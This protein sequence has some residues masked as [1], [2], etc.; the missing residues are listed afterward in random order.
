MPGEHTTCPHHSGVKVAIEN[1]SVRFTAMSETDKDQWDSIEVLQTE[2]V[3]MKLF[4][5]LITVL[6]VI[7][8]GIFGINL[9]AQ[10]KISDIQVQQAVI[11]E[12]VK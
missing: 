1:L 7:F 5:V 6:C 4:Y 3:P 9:S 11:L 10:S 2:K 12:K 8:I